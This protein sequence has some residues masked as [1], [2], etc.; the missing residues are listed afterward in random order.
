VSVGLSALVLVFQDGRFEDALSYTSQGG[1]LIPMAVM[2][3]FTAFGLSTDYGVFTLSRIR[4]AHAAGAD[5]DEAVALGMER[6][7]RIVTSAALLFAVAMGALVT[8]ALIGVKETGV[9]IAVAVLVDATLVR[10]FL[11]PSL[12]ALLGDRNWWAPRRLRA[13]APLRQ[14]G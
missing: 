2:I 13:L 6:T 5:N 1:I 9:G 7:G 3:A 8:G 4:E 10:A 12:M 11:V 14:E